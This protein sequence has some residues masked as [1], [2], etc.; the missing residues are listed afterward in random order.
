MSHLLTL[1]FCLLG[2]IALAL[3]MERQQD[4]LFDR[5]LPQRTTRQLRLLGSALLLLA[6]GVITAA[7]GWGM[8]LVSYSGHTSLAAGVVYGVLILWGRR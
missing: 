5:S 6:L 1:L 8:G 2:F 4:E 7:Q 3:A